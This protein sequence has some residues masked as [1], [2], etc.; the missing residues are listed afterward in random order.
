[1]NVVK[2]DLPPLRE[3]TED[4][5][6]LVT[7]FTEKYAHGAEPAKQISPEAMQVL[8]NHSWPGNIREL[9]NTIERA[10]V[11]TRDPVIQMLNLPPELVNPARPDVPFTVDMTK[12]LRELVSDAVAKI[13]AH[14]IREILVKTHG[15][16]GRCAEICGFSRRCITS[17]MVEY[18]LDKAD[19]RDD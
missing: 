14:Y 10:C 12:P 15:H 16:I 3:R 2:I 1:M 8:L 7:H 11:T 5:P 13:E 18:Q 19:F 9:E 17:K 6:L 4:I